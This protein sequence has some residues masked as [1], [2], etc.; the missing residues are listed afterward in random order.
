[1]MLRYRLE[2][3]AI[4]P[5]GRETVSRDWSNDLAVLTDPR[6]FAGEDRITGWTITSD[7]TPEQARERLK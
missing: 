4:S 1:M 6:L 3:R 5:S 7:E 2:I